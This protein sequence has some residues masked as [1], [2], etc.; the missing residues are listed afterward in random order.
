MVVRIRLGRG[1]PFPRREAANSGVAR[2]TASL[3]TIVSISL[4]SFGLWRVGADLG[5]AGDFVFRSGILSHWQ[6]WIAGACVAQY[7]AWRLSR[8]ARK[9]VQT[10]PDTESAEE[11]PTVVPVVSNV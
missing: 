9:T 3:M 6:V 7:L 5:W 10:L 8:Y 4:G 11:T 1:T 2:L